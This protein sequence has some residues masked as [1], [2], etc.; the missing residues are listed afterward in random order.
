M[1][2]KSRSGVKPTSVYARTSVLNRERY[3]LLDGMSSVSSI[4]IPDK[5]PWR[6]NRLRSRS[7]ISS[8]VKCLERAW[9][10]C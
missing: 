10:I 3:A 9:M 7:S 2:A 6:L 8:S 1:N 5:V 4:R